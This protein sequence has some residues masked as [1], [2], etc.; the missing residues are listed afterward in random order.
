MFFR[1][2]LDLRPQLCFTFSR[3]FFFFLSFFFFFS[4]SYTFWL[5]RQWTVHLC[6]VH[7]S[8][9]LHFSTTFS[10]KMG[11][12]IL[13]TYL[14]IILLQYFQFQQNKFYTLSLKFLYLFHIWFTWWGIYKSSQ[15]IINNLFSFKSWWSF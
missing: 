12:M 10:L 2:G 15:H 8:H 4:F 11:S 7:G 5:S 1:C 6:T 3:I 13:F 9:K 14:K